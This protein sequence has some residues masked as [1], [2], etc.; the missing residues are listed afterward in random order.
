MSKT[1]ALQYKRYILE[2]TFLVIDPSSGRS[3]DGGWA[4]FEN[5]K[6][7]ESG[8]IEISSIASKQKRLVAILECMQSQFTDPVDLLVLEKIDGRMAKRILIQACG[9][10]IA[11]APSKV[12]FE[13]NVMTWRSIASKLGGWKK[14]SKNT[15]K[16]HGDSEGNEGDEIDAQYIGWASIALA[17]GYDTKKKTKAGEAERMEIIQQVR[18]RM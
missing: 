16:V 7:K 2:G 4:L 3:G 5:G 12:Y 14:V 15:G 6:L 18:E 13:M 10:F 11:T 8:V 1:R 17:L 9:V